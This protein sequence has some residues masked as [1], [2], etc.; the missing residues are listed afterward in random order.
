MQGRGGIGSVRGV[1]QDTAASPSPLPIPYFL[2]C[3]SGDA[4]RQEDNDKYFG[5]FCAIIGAS[6]VDISSQ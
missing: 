4:G 6:P 3:T 5:H 2:A 1:E